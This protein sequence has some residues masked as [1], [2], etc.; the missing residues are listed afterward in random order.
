MP[1]LNCPDCETETLEPVQPA[2]QPLQIVGVQSPEDL[3]T[4]P[5]WRRYECTT[6][7]KKVWLQDD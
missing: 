7:E 4:G 5:Y 6:C 3:K 1:D 2:D